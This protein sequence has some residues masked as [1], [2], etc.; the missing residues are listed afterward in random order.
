MGRVFYSLTSKVYC[1]DVPDHSGPSVVTQPR[2]ATFSGRGSK[3]DSILG[4]T[5]ASGGLILGTNALIERPT[6]DPEGQKAI[7]T[8]LY[9][10]LP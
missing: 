7:C 8:A 6:Q 10:T 1:G 9:T 3:P 4:A 2:V 5:L